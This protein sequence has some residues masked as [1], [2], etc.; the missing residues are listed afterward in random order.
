MLEAY[1]NLVT[2]RGELQGIAAA[3]R[4]L[5]D[6][7]PGG[8][9]EAESLVL[10]AL[11]RSPNAK[12][13]AASKLAEKPSRPGQRPATVTTRMF[14][15]RREFRESP[16]ASFRDKKRVVAETSG[17]ALSRRDETLD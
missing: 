10:A 12:P 17:A 2:F 1:L 15:P 14:L 11:I 3:A 16:I 5:F 9:D 4:G 6:K 8:L 7:D 13:G